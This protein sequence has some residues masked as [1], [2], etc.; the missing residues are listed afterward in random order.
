MPKAS[1]ER[2]TV[3]AAD[4]W[5]TEHLYPNDA[6]WE[7]DRQ[8]LVASLAGIAECRGRFKGD[9]ALVLTCLERTFAA[10]KRY[11]RLA[12]YASRR[13][14][15]DT[16]VPGYQGM[17]EVIEKVGTDFRATT[18]FIEPELLSLPA[19]FLKGLTGAPDFADYDRYL[20]EVL[21][22]KPHIL[23]PA[24]EGLLAQAS[25]M[26][27]AGYNAYSAF[28]GA[29]LV[30]PTVKDERGKEVRLTQALFSRFRTS[31]DRKVR[32][33]A[34]DTLFS[35]YHG[36]R[37]TLASLLSAQVNANL[38]FV[39]ARK[40][41][42]ALE[43]ALYPDDIPVSVYENMI[44]AVNRH[45]PTLHRYLALRRKRLGLKQL[46][47]Y[48]LYAPIVEKVTLR[49]PVPKARQTLVEALAPLGSP[50]TEALARGLAADA[51]WLDLVP[52]K[53]KRSGAYMDG[54]AYDVH[55]FVLGNYLDDY[56]S[57]S[58]LAHEMGHAMHSHFSN[59]HQPYPKADYSIFTAEVAS[60][61][62]EAL[63]AEH[64]LRAAKRPGEQLFLLGEQ[65][66]GFR[67]TLFR[68]CLFAEFELELYRR[69]ERQEALTADV[70]SEL[71][72]KLARRY[73]GHDDKVVVVDEAYAAEWAYIPHFFYNFYVFQYV[74]GITAATALA[75]LIR[76]QGAT[77]RDRYLD[78][79]IKA[80]G[81]DAPIEI[82]KRAGVDLRTT[83]P[84]DL[85]VG[86]FNRT[87]DRAEALS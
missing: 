74:T 82:L 46:H 27:N 61:L 4:K 35:T 25:Q 73:Y 72:L 2:S 67:L 71:Y 16:R 14:D 79:L 11:A 28:S 78:N 70:L 43:A 42:S 54:S 80:G 50:Y 75:E 32:K 60:T 49:Y 64:L 59:R 20:R 33:A 45:L 47:Y 68:Q 57:L 81:S 22:L 84:Y 6:A 56:N 19:S 85:A 58:M 52:N 9:R 65:M 15:E 55:P 18:A 29:D 31:P 21:R 8:A 13:H 48:D 83:Q 3:A 44:A 12:N 40:Y 1:P 36:Y 77:A 69:A 34:F 17:K 30:F 66:E 26:Q 38:V 41:S 86:V 87:L 76:E 24:E 51:G 5:K 63:L 39:K 23:S 53:G 37:N 62:N 7:K 10:R